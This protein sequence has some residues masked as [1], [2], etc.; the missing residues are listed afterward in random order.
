MRAVLLLL[1]C[2]G[3]LVSPGGAFAQNGP[4]PSPLIPTPAEDLPRVPDGKVYATE[5]WRLGNYDVALAYFAQAYA[6][7]LAAGDLEGMAADLNQIGLIQWRLNDCTSAMAA[8][9]ESARLAEQCGM[10]RLL[11]LTYL[12][13]AILLKNQGLTDSAFAMNAEALRTFKRL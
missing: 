6:D 2:L 4:Q 9:T 5:Q 1:L 13:R 10:E 8:Y 7:D 11:G 3:G 12:N